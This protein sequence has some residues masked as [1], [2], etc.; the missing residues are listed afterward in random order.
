MQ[1]YQSLVE[2][3]FLQLSGWESFRIAPTEKIDILITS[4]FPDLGKLAALRFLEFVQ[5]KPDGVV[6]LP[7]GKTPEYFIKWVKH[8]LSTWNSEELHSLGLVDMEKPSFERLKFVQMDE[9]FPIAPQQTNSFAYFVWK[10]YIESFGIKPENCLLID[11]CDFAPP[12]LFP[13][14]VDLGIISKLDTELNPLE[15]KQKEALERTILYCKNYEEKINSLGGIDFFLGGIGPDGHVAFNIR[16]SS[17]DS[18]TRLLKLNYE[19]MAASAESLGGMSTARKKLVITIG[20]ETITR[21][22]SCEAHLF[23]AGEAKADLVREAVEGALNPTIP[24]HALRSLQKSVI[25]LTKGASKKLSSRRTFNRVKTNAVMA[26]L[27]RGTCSSFHSMKFLHTEPHHDDI[28]LGYLPFILKTRR[29]ERLD[30]FACGTSGFNSVSNAFLNSVLKN[31][32]DMVDSGKISF[33]LEENAD[34]DVKIFAQGFRKNDASLQQNAVVRRFIRNLAHNETMKELDIKQKIG[35]I[36]EYLSSLYPG[37]KDANRPDIQI[38]RGE[39]REFESECLWACLGYDMAKVFHLRLGFYT[40]ETFSPQPVFE[41]D[42]IPFLKILLEQRPDVVTVALDPESSGPD[43]HYKVLQA[44]TSA[45][46]EYQL[47]QGSNQKEPLVWGYRNVWYRFELS[48]TNLIIPVTLEEMGNTMD[49]FGSCYISQKNAEFP[50]YLLDGPFSEIV[51]NTWKTQHAEFLEHA[52]AGSLPAGTE[53]LIYI[54][55][56]TINELKSYS[57]SLSRSI[58]DI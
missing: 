36:S 47:M 30:V 56:M 48:E 29:D 25:Y 14:G 4:T 28:M 52:P 23:V 31:A 33:L 21:N 7:T 57:R 24:S 38:M 9:F 11:T 51:V 45:L 8:F 50:S 32:L 12:S 41:R 49:L 2:N 22:Q 26:A 35:S 27:Q 15:R 10:Y 43:T 6:S 18:V 44:V 42:S 55:E 20:L 5:K 16:G 53:G 58:E 19:S 40:I 46:T 17:F 13:D 1:K 3:R 37:Q 34:A 39:C 54:K